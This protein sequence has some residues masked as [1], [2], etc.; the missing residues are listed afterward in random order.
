MPFQSKTDLRGVL[1]FAHGARASSW[2]MPFDSL[3][4]LVAQQ[5]V[6]EPVELA[7]LEFMQPDFA[8]GIQ[9]LVNLGVR[10]VQICLL[11]L[12]KGNHTVRDLEELIA[13][14]Q[15]EHPELQFTV[16]SAML[17]D[18][19]V[20]QASSEWVIELLRNDS[21][22]NSTQEF[23]LEMRH[24]ISA[25]VLLER[26]AK[27]LMLH[28]VKSGVYDFWAP[29]GG[30]VKQIED[31]RTA[32]HREAFEETGI[33]VQTH[34]LLFVE[35]F[36]QPG[37]R[38]IKSWFRATE[39]DPTVLPRLSAEG[40]SEHIVEIAF[41]SQEQIAHV[42]HFPEFLRHDY[43]AAAK[44]IKSNNRSAIPSYRGLRSMRAW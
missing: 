9:R 3:R 17:E 8:E 32:A 1:L 4:A 38:H 37:L 41:L 2:R 22:E 15:S 43:W 44:E 36:Y 6:N 34:E 21:S 35:E 10:R 42:G 28:F 30:G 5:L 24:R 16:S 33:Q 26:D 14:A 27:L 40:V 20:L 31:L 7:F 25:G 12:A 18:P 23:A 13:K 39:S 11:F 29:P 19:R